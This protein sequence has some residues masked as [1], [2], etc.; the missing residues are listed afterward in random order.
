MENCD[1]PIILNTL[2]NSKIHQVISG[3]AILEAIT[4]SKRLLE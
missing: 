1:K 4:E 2:S 3:T